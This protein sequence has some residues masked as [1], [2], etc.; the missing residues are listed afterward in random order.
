MTQTIAEIR[1][2][3]GE[4]EK[5]LRESYTEA[6][7]ERLKEIHLDGLVR[8][9]SDGRLGWLEVDFYGALCFYPQT[10]TGERSIIQNG[11]VGNV[12][13]NFEPY[14]DE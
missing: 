3:Y 1:K 7:N 13:E 11:S 8:R 14:V 6:I 4:D 10:K 9:K 5:A 2:K 12:E